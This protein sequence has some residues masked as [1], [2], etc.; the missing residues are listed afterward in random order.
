MPGRTPTSSLHNM[1]TGKG[2]NSLVKV[3][4]A[5]ADDWFLKGGHGLVKLA[6]QI[7][8]LPEFGVIFCPSKHVGCSLP[9]SRDRLLQPP[10]VQYVQEIFTASRCQMHKSFTGAVE[11]ITMT[12]TQQVASKS[13]HVSVHLLQS[14]SIRETLSCVDSKQTCWALFDF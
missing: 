3:P 5:Q 6:R 8:N 9:V 10:K 2:S 1:M 13:H 11:G 7:Q 14:Q 4:V 12:P